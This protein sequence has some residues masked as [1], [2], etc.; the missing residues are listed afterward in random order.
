MGRPWRIGF[1][2][3]DIS[4]TKGGLPCMY[5]YADDNGIEIVGTEI[6]PP[7]TLDYSTNIKRLVDAG[8]DVIFVSQCGAAAGIALK[9]M[10]DMGIL[11][12]LEEAIASPDK[13]VPLLNACAF[14]IGS[15]QAAPEV[16][17]YVYGSALWG[18]WDEMNDFPGVKQRNDW[19]VAKYGY[20]WHSVEQDE[21]S[22]ND[23][24]NCMKIIA[25]AIERTVKA[26][27]WEKLDSEAVIQK[28]LM[29]LSITENVLGAHLSYADYEGDR[30]ALELLRPATWSY[31]RGTTVAISDYVPVDR[32]Y[33]VPKY[34]PKKP[35]P[36]MYTD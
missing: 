5:K 18:S 11:A 17:Q 23:G 3:M 14:R 20:I 35:H 25:A 22:F 21:Q 12:P 24:W 28:G 34:T 9:Q 7:P 6:T 15:M 31:K 27:G 29:G 10:L 8:A 4:Y 32:K 13:I 36:G 30:I 26:V 19:M 1:L 16:A 33:Y 2:T